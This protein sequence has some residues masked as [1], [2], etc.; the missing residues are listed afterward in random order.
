MRAA[1]LTAEGPVTVPLCARCRPRAK[2]PSL[3]E[4]TAIGPACPPPGPWPAA[5]GL[6]SVQSG[7]LSSQTVSHW[8]AEPDICPAP[9]PACARAGLPELPTEASP[10]T[11]KGGRC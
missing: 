5:W 8:P 10:H 11:G 1:C 4:V 6:P 7:R 9:G 3:R 2:W